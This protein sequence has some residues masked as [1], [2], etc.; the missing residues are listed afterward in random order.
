MKLASCFYK[1]QVYPTDFLYGFYFSFKSSKR[2]IFVRYEPNG[3]H[4]QNYEYFHVG[5][6]KADKHTEIC[7]EE[8]D[9]WDKKLPVLE[10]YLTDD[11]KKELKKFKIHKFFAGEVSELPCLYDDS[12]PLDI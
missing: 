9:D 5:L 1:T 7:Y 4:Q 11:E 10:H 8:F 6:I 2:F 12:I 3:L